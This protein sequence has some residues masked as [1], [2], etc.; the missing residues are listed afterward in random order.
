MGPFKSPS[1]REGRKSKNR[2][3]LCVRM[4]DAVSLTVNFLNFRASLPFKQVLASSLLMFSL[5]HMEL[6]TLYAGDFDSCWGRPKLPARDANGEVI[7]IDPSAESDC[8]LI[9]W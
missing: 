2:R 5:V 6:N 1:R 8:I 9:V 4:I 7:L 3:K